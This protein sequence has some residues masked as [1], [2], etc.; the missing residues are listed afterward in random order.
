LY[1]PYVSSS[2]SLLLRFLF[3]LLFLPRL[4]IAIP[5]SFGH[6]AEEF[7][8]ET[9][10]PIA[11]YPDP[12]QNLNWS[13]RPDG[14][15]L[16]DRKI[17]LRGTNPTI[18]YHVHQFVL[19]NGSPVF[20]TLFL[21]NGNEETTILTLEDE[22]QANVFHIILDYLYSL[23]SEEQNSFEGVCAG[24][25]TEES[26][27]LYK[28]ADFLLIQNLCKTLTKCW[29]TSMK[30]RDC[31]VFLKLAANSPGDVALVEIIAQKYLENIATLATDPNIR[32]VWFDDFMLAVRKK[33]TSGTHDSYRVDLVVDRFLFQK[34]HVE[35]NSLLQLA[36][37]APLRPRV[38]AG[39]KQHVFHKLVGIGIFV[40]LLFGMLLLSGELTVTET[41]S[42]AFIVFLTL[43]F[44]WDIAFSLFPFFFY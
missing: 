30:S 38:V 37:I 20:K 15:P 12:D 42:G 27:A 3:F 5:Y 16:L 17:E 32:K 23:Y 13:T 1:K 6:Q 8:F 22:E 43:F 41:I 19:A 2:I 10:M 11:N 40:V 31:E 7:Y 33:S 14:S 9:I 25:M 4:V 26:V 18:F 34:E 44:L 29:K 36:N 39:M 24:L 28:V 35:G 21:R